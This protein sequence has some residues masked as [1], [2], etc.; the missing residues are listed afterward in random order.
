MAF[1]G[2][3]VCTSFK[4]D[5][6]TGRMNFAASNG[7]P[8]TQDVFNLSLYTSSATLDATT[9]AYTAT[10]EHGGTGTYVARGKVV[11]VTA[12]FPKVVTGV[13]SVV[14]FDDLTWLAST[15]TAR[16]ALIWNDT[17]AAPTADPSIVV[18]DFLADKSSSA[19]DFT[20]VF[21]AG[22]TA[23]AIIRIA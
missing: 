8:G 5:L 18:L 3:Y 6:L 16:G 10:G 22:D 9:V 1:T 12:T 17:I 14:D 15:I 4:T 11:A 21:P 2:N 13:T 20:V 19:G 7:R 23:N